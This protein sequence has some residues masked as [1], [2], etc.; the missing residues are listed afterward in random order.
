MLT[1]LLSTPTAQLGKASRFVV[2]QIKLWSHCARLLKKNR[3][4]QQAAAL[5]YH[6]IF[7]IVPLV[8]VMLLIFHS[9]PAYSDIG[10]KVKSMIYGQLHLANIEYQ[11]TDLD[12]QGKTIAITEYIDEIVGGF[13]SASTRAQ[14]L[15]SAA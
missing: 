12:N 1:K 13:L 5:S 11:S 8:I 7:G 15:F 9:F 3:S 2:F 14:S 6:T 10:E 4:G